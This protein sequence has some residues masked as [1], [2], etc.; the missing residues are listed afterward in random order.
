MWP[1]KTI[2]YFLLFWGGCVV[3]LVN[4]IWGVV[5]YVMA[6]QTNPTNTWWGA[7][8]TAMGIRFSMFAAA[9][10]ILGLVFGRKFVPRVRPALSMWEVGAIA[11]VF[12][13]AIN[14]IL[15][16]G[17][18][19]TSRYAFEKLW[20]MTLFTL[21]LARLASTRANLKLV[22]W[23]LVGGS[24]Y[25]GHDAYTAHP[26]A[27]FHGR[28]EMIGG[29]DFATTSGMAAH[30]SAMLPLIGAAF[31]TARTWKWRAFAAV[32]GAFAFNAVVLCRTRSA[33][34]GLTCGVLAAILT[35]PRARRFRIHLLLVTGTIMAFSLT[36]NH[37]WDRMQ[38]LTSRESLNKDAAAVSRFEIWR[39]SLDILLD[40]PAGVGAGNFPRVVGSYDPRHYRRSSH[41]TLIVC[42]TELGFQGGVVFLLLIAGSL[43]CL[44]RSAKLA[45][46]TDDPLET[47]FLTYG[48]LVSFVTY[49][50]TGLGTERFYCESFWWVLV[51]PLCLH[52]AVLR[53]VA[54]NQELPCED[55]APEPAGGNAVYGQLLH[56]F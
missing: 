36:D 14:L 47:K 52:R 29:P 10:T 30:L 51:L 24:L 17:Y 7:P 41:N 40:H 19:P 13:A 26:S 54:A 16:S 39:V 4:P 8:L 6:Y 9:A 43:R 50:V 22:L 5:N 37:F 34:V 1:L 3:A 32:A 46:H 20:K 18:H 38:T 25:L 23:S 33:F 12:F 49:V 53:E 35:A 42:F 21:I 15:G 28:L 55:Q 48:L 11:L 45:D 27:F 31:L 44:Y 56:D 2:M